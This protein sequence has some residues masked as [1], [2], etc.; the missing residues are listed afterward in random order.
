MKMKRQ[1]ILAIL[2]I[3]LL[4]VQPISADCL[5]KFKDGYP[6]GIVPS[7][8]NITAVFATPIQ[9]NQTFKLYVES[10]FGTT[11]SIECRV[12]LTVENETDALKIELSN[13]SLETGAAF[14]E[15]PITV[16]M[17]PHNLVNFPDE[18]VSQIKITDVDDPTNFAI[19]PILGKFK[20]QRVK[21]VITRSP[22]AD[23]PTDTSNPY[24]SAKATP[25]NSTNIIGNIINTVEDSSSK[26]VIA[27]IAFVF[28]AALLWIGFNSLQR[29]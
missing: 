14:I 15:R 13:Y 16:I 21:P 23:V 7:V 6:L 18:I 29:E 11:T 4:L 28:L 25:T 20:F 5:Y 9:Q 10:Q 12:Y 1:L 27:I 2:G 22:T 3:M 26:Y 24:V 8:R 19:L 17:T